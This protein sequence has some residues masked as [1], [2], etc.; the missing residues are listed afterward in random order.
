MDDAKPVSTPLAAHLK[1]SQEDCPK[2]SKEE[3]EMQNTPYTSAVVS[4]MYAMVCTRPDIAR[5]VGTLSRYMS[6]PRPN[7]WEAVKW[8]LRYLKGTSSN[9]LCFGG[10]NFHVNG[11]VDANLGGDLDTGR[12][13]MGYVLTCGGAAAKYSNI[14]YN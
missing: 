5:A 3:N 14:V 1:L 11:Y 2:N 8:L 12:S 9:Y 6:N 4:L 13:T 10:T 7:H